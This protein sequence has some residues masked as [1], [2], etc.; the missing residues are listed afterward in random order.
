MPEWS[1]SENSSSYR[2]PTRKT[3]KAAGMQD[4]ELARAIE[5]MAGSLP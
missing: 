1:G 5:P 2:C 4:L 3:E